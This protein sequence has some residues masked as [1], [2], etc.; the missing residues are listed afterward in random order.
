MTKPA[1]TRPL[2]QPYMGLAEIAAYRGVTKQTVSNWR[3]RGK[4]PKPYV[5]LAMGPVW[6]IWD[7]VDHFKQLDEEN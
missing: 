2:N 3:S 7:I 5:V 6:Y 1:V 4:L